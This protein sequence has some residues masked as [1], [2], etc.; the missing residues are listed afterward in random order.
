M[1]LPPFG[2]IEILVREKS[3][4]VNLDAKECMIASCIFAPGPLERRDA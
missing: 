4:S 3:L 1:I 2:K